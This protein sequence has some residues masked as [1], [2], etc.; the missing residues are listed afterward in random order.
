MML[1]DWQKTLLGMQRRDKALEAIKDLLK[2]KGSNIVQINS[3]LAGLKSK[4]NQE[5]DHSQELTGNI[6]IYI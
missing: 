3:E 6:S 1:E 2:A 5:H 4:L